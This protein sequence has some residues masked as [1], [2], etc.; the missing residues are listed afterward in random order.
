[1]GRHQPQVV[2]LQPLK[3]AQ[4]EQKGD[5]VGSARNPEN[6]RP[7]R[8]RQTQPTPFGDQTASKTV[9]EA[10]LA[11]NCMNCTN[12]RSGIVC[13]GQELSLFGLIGRTLLDQHRE[14]RSADQLTAVVGDI[15]LPN[16][17]RPARV[18]GRGFNGKNP[19]ADRAHM[20]G[21]YFDA[22]GRYFLEICTSDDADR[23]GGFGEVERDASV[24]YADVLMY[25]WRDGHCQHHAFG[26]CDLDLYAKELQQLIFGCLLDELCLV[27]QLFRNSLADASAAETRSG[28]V[29]P[30]AVLL[31][32]AASTLSA[33]KTS[34]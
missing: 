9:H 34:A 20:I 29:P 3:L 1:M 10:S 17:H 24:H 13:E 28:D 5:R 25:L 32:S 11:T 31:A 14:A 2:F 33:A 22:D 26:G 7:V 21:I 12:S 8:R 18:D 15:D 27:H 23:C 6:D 4:S 16:A 19:F 30:I